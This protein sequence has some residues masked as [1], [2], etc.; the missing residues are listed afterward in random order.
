M[1]PA[2][3]DYLATACLSK[4]MAWKIRGVEAKSHSTRRGTPQG[5]SLSI[6]LFQVTLSPVVHALVEFL[7]ARSPHA[8]VIV[9]ADDI[10][11]LTP[12][13]ELLAE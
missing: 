7:R 8:A 4:E 3:A 6:L 5:C 9:Y 1:P 13:P 2:F 12:T 10:V 11:F